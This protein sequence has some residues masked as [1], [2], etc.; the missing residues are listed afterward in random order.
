MA[1]FNSGLTVLVV[2]D[3]RQPNWYPM[4]LFEV[5]E[6]V[7]PANWT[8]ALRNGGQAGTQAVWGHPRLVNDSALDES[9]A[10]QDSDAQVIFWQDVAV[11]EGVETE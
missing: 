10:D 3:K 7:L 11:P 8:F 9:L 6:G 2:D 1:L 5:E 4:E